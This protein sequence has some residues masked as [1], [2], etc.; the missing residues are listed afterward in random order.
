MVQFHRSADYYKPTIWHS[1]AT[2]VDLEFVLPDKYFK[3][4]HHADPNDPL[5]M[6]IQPEILVNTEGFWIVNL[7]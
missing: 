5:K 4:N 2:K 6:K 1:M 3:W 7:E